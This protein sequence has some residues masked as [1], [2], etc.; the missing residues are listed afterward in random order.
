MGDKS[1]YKKKLIVEKAREVFAAK[2]FTD[3]TMKDV[4][5]A[6]GISR[7]G[8]Y[9]Y[10]S[11]TEELFLEVL[12][13]ESLEDEAEVE[14]ALA[15]ELSAGDMLAVFLKEQ[16]KE[17]LRKKNNLLAATYEYYFAHR[18]LGAENPLKQDFDKAVM[19]LSKLIENGIAGNEFVCEEPLSYARNIMYVIEGLKVCSRTMGVTEGAV[20]RELVYL[21]GG[22]VPE[23][24]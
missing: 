12:K 19:I 1:L 6:C 24:G 16:K 18:S 9:L 20:D 2:G 15:G 14:K 21:I 5:E 4:V 13:A 17:I 10:F 8:L 7:G 3:V 22:L 11:S 23:E